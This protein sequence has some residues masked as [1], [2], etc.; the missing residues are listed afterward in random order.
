MTTKTIIDVGLFFKKG[1]YRKLLHPCIA[2]KTKTSTK[3]NLIF[4]HSIDKMYKGIELKLPS[5]LS[6]ALLTEVITQS[7]P[8]DQMWV[9]ESKI[10]CG[11]INVMVILT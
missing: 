6:R 11:I 5:S 1:V 9:T 2:S 3:V 4:W 10:H 8:I 7:Y